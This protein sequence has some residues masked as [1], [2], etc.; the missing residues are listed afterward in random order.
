MKLLQIL[1]LAAVSFLAVGCACKDAD[2]CKRKAAN[3]HSYGIMM[4][5]SY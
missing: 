2:C 1:L 5:G 3:N 4:E